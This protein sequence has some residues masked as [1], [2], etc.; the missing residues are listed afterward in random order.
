MKL[1]L[2]VN[3]MRP[4][5]LAEKMVVTVYLDGETVVGLGFKEQRN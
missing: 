2:K 1:S 4:S 3:D 5:E